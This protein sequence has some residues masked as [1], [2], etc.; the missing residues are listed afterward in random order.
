MGQQ[1]RQVWRGI[2]QRDLERFVVNRTHAQFFWRQFG[3]VHLGGVL[4]QIKQRG[5]LR[6]DF[7]GLNTAQRK[8]EVVCRYRCAI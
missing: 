7:R 6:G 1:A 8:D 4:D 5:I 2:F 3:R